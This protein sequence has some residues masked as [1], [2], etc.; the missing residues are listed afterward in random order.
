[1]DTIH[2]S[3][4]SNESNTTFSPSS[5]PTSSPT[6]APIQSIYSPS[7]STAEFL[8]QLRISIPLSAIIIVIY[9][10]VRRLY[11]NTFELKRK[12]S[13]KLL[14]KTNK[15]D[16]EDDDKFNDMDK[17]NKNNLDSETKR[18]AFPDLSNG[19]VSWILDVWFMD[20][21]TF[22][23][24]AGFDALIFRLYLKGCSYICIASLPYLLLVLLPIYATSE[25][26]ILFFST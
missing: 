8:S 2:T 18:I 12:I 1:M 23:I 21:Q 10:I 26:S 6:N 25:V 20:N 11:P 19:Y 4:F 15:D 16:D 22:Y 17:I 9:C 3:L 24:H 14:T 7:A 13:Q 5:S